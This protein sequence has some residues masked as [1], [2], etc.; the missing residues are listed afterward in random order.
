M[1]CNTYQ[2]QIFFPKLEYFNKNF[3]EFAMEVGHQDLAVLRYRAGLAFLLCKLF[4]Q[5]YPAC[6]IC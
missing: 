4:L 3:S 5:I 1:K 2:D 6:K